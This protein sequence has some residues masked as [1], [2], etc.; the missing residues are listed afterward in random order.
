[1]SLTDLLGPSPEIVLIAAVHH[2][3]SCRV[4]ALMR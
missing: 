3:Y 2:V 1:M 4:V